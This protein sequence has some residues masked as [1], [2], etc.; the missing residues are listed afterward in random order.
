[1]NKDMRLGS[2]IS[3]YQEAHPKCHCSSLGAG[4]AEVARDVALKSRNEPHCRSERGQ[5]A[6]HGFYSPGG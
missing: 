3:G 4:T 6:A 1:M 2:Q 5:V